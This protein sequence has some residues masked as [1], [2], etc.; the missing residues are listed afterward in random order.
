M[1]RCAICDCTDEDNPKANIKLYEQALS[2][3]HTR[4]EFRCLECSHVIDE[5]LEDLSIADED[6]EFQTK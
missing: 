4:F 2:P 1:N 3:D 5:N 6:F